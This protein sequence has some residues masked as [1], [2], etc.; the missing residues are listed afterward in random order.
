MLEKLDNVS[1]VVEKLSIFD[2]NFVEIDEGDDYLYNYYN[3]YLHHKAISNG[4]VLTKSELL[5]V[6]HFPIL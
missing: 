2:S 5:S 1:K 4:S 6:F 3:S